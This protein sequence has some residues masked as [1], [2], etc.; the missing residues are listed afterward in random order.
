MAKRLNST[1]HVRDDDGR[2][3][4][5]GP[6]DDVP[7]WAA[8]KITNPAVWGE[9]VDDDYADS[10]ALASSGAV[11][12]QAQQAWQDD[13]LELA[14]HLPERFML[15]LDRLGT[16]GASLVSYLVEAMNEDAA[17]EDAN[18]DGG[19][20]AGDDA[21]DT[22]YG[23]QPDTGTAPDSS[24]PARNASREAWAAY[25]QGVG[26]DVPLDATRDQIRAAVDAATATPAADATPPASA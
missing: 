6:D 26:V 15:E 20:A 8:A 25:A 3:H 1:V 23:G 5:F 2:P 19:P 10:D 14:A 17:R 24:A 22:G 7:G 13:M 9:D 11:D 12:L 16:A 4:A 18:D 21:A